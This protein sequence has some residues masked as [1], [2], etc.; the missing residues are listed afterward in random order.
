MNPLSG[1]VPEA[2]SESLEMGFAAASRNVFRIVAL[3]TGGFA[4]E[5]LSRRKGNAGATRG[6]QGVGRAAG[7]R[8]R[9]L[10][11]GCLVAPLRYLFGLLEASCK[12]RTLGE[13]FVQFREYFLTRISETKNSRKQQLA[14]RHLVNR[15]TRVRATPDWYDPALNVKIVDNNDDDPATYEEAMMSPDS[16]KWQEAMKSEMGSMYD[17]QVWTLVDLPDSRKAVENKWIFKRKTDANGDQEL[18]VTSY[19]D[20]SWNTDPD[21]SKSQSGYVFIL[22]GAAVSW[23]SAKQSVVAKSSTE[24]EYIAASEASSEAIWMKCF[25]TELGVVPSA[26]DPMTIYCDNMG[27]IANAQE[28]R[29]HKKLKHIKLRFHSIREYVEDGDIKICKVHT[30]LN[31]ADPLTKALPRA[32]HDLHQ[33]AM[34]VRYIT[35]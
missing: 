16:N 4:T 24:S 28:P 22:N 9:R 2:I 14:L 27:A 30:D 23:R 15:S 5:T 18:A 25:I 10:S 11:P 1:R 32:K 8:P 31:V 6:A 33:N 19:T 13:S 29:S 12:N 17:N 34:G 21:D 35:M 3:G 20:A 26:L 7:H